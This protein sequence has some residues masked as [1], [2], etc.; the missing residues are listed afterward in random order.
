MAATEAGLAAVELGPADA[1]DALA[2]SVEAGWNQT[3][4]DWQVFLDQ[5]LVFGLREP[6]GRLVASAA[7]LPMPP[8]AWI[9]MVLVT[10]AWRRRGLASRLMTACIDEARRAGL[11]AWLDATPA[12]AQV[13]GPLGFTSRLSLQRFRRAPQAEAV[14]AP[15]GHG[16]LDDLVARDSEAMGCDRGALLA[17]FA[18]RPGSRIV[19]LGGAIALVRGG[20]TARQIGPVHAPR[21]SEAAALVDA[22]VRDEGGPHIMD[23][24]TPTEA[25]TAAL[26]AAG[27]S[28]ER[29]F[30][31]MSFATAVTVAGATAFAVAGP[32]FG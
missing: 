3:L 29:P 9:S 12:G 20:R 17:A 22:I 2:L 7:L 32:E 25:E 31:R 23:V 5:G 15:L 6:Q 1:G 10:A 11:A 16:T 30:T 8:A 24:V 26:G 21:R 27:W 18:A 14:A 4:A 28:F 13:Y 19:R